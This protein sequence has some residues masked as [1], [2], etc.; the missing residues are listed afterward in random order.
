MT[1]RTEPL[2]AATVSTEVIEV[3]VRGTDQ[4]LLLDIVRLGV[5]VVKGVE[6]AFTLDGDEIGL[7]RPCCPR[8]P[9][10]SPTTTASTPGRW[11]ASRGR[12]MYRVL[13]FL[14]L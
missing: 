9:A 6:V 8:R 10:P 12:A 3:V 7:G 11:L 14:P 4:S 1:I 13:Y 5:C 2:F